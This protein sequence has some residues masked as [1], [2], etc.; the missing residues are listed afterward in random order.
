MK[1]LLVILALFGAV[2]TVKAQKEFNRWSL[3]INGGFNKPMGP[4]TPGYL[5]PTLNIGHV[6]GGLRYMFNEYFGIKGDLGFGNFNEAGGDSNS[7]SF[8]TNYSRTNLQGVA[9]VGRLLSFEKIS[10]NLT[11]LGHFGVGGG[12]MRF[13]ES[14]ITNTEYDYHYNFI[15]GISPQ[16]LI[17]N[18]LA[19][20]TDISVIING[21]QTYTFDGNQY[22]APY[23][24]TSP[25][26]N[27]FIHATGTW[28]TGTLGLN[29]Y[30]GKQEQHADWYLAP[31]KYVT[32]DE[33]ESQVG[34]IKD[35]LKDSDGDGVPDYLD[36]E[37]NTP[38][39]ARVNSQGTTMDSDKDGTPDHLDECP[40]IPGPSATEG[41]PVEQGT[42]EVDYI[43]RAINDQYLNVYFAFDSS[44]PLNFSVSS[45]QFVS[46]FLKR[47][48][49]T[50]LE[51][52]GYADELGGEN[53]N[54]VLS[55]L[56]AKAVY[57]I[58]ID[59]GIIA[60]RLYFKG[61]GEDTS[62]DKS[63]A[64]ARQMARRVSFEVK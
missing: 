18:R 11:V 14:I 53:Y 25:N 21:R 4:L 42:N 56:R 46:N 30:L 24:I 44:K 48:P 3:E 51:I 49:D 5:S 34:A 26:S 38:T 28:W 19:L 6:E 2:S 43:K 52:K 63:S 40:F 31:E 62:V 1:K 45:I 58:L 47:N 64:D 13:Q 23:P 39:D 22:N 55:E 12:R 29:F 60:D 59:S 36:K 37:P 27:P 32:K 54:L 17:S 9:N 16:Y 15:T 61:M 33:L 35:M 41:C 20:K 50:R 7:P 10:P 57:Q 8:S